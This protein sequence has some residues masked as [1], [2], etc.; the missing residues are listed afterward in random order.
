MSVSYF[1]DTNVLVYGYAV[2]EPEK[3]RKAWQTVTSEVFYN[4]IAYCAGM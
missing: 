1:V 2:S 3:Q 4:W